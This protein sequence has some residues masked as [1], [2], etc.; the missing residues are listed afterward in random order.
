MIL[1]YEEAFGFTPI[2]KDLTD[3]LDVQNTIGRDLTQELYGQEDTPFYKDGSIITCG[4]FL[5]AILIAF[6]LLRKLAPA[7]LA[8]FYSV[9]QKILIIAAVL[10]TFWMFRY[11]VTT[12]HPHQ[13]LD[14][15][16]GEVVRC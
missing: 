8:N 5:L 11:E 2:V 13:C 16:Y 3:V 10:F 6:F 12:T 15:W 4:L 9:F 1:S 14:R 7:K